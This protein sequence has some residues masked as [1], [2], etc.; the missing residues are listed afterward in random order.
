MNKLYFKRK[1]KFLQLKITTVI[2]K[3]GFYIFYS[4]VV[5]YIVATRCILNIL[6]IFNEVHYFLL[7]SKNILYYAIYSLQ[8][9]YLYSV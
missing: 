3:V 9:K 1:D 7:Y 2:Q 4:T 8:N 5:G 6:L